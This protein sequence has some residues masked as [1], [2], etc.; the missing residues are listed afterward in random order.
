MNKRAHKYF[1]I[2]IICILCGCNTNSSDVNTVD[3][4]NFNY[5]DNKLY[6]SISELEDDL[7]NNWTIQDSVY[8]GYCS[9]N[10][11]T[12]GSRYGVGIKNFGENPSIRQLLSSYGKQFVYEMSTVHHLIYQDIVALIE[13]ADAFETNMYAIFNRANKEDGFGVPIYFGH[14]WWQYDNWQYNNSGSYGWE[15]SDV[16]KRILSNLSSYANNSDYTIYMPNFYVTKDTYSLETYT[17]TGSA[18]AYVGV[19]RIST[20]RTAYQKYRFNMLTKTISS[21]NAVYDMYSDARDNNL[22]RAD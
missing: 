11:S 5:F 18:Y 4:P 16:G 22:I 17:F 9:L 19:K 15:N 12:F 14:T 21:M 1:L 7:I 6:S 8:K 2:P 3:E 10:S 20:N 13:S